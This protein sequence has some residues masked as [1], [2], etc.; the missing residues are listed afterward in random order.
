MCAIGAVK[1]LLLTLQVYDQMRIHEN[2][3]YVERKLYYL[4]Y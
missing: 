2:E 3:T 4:L 1:L